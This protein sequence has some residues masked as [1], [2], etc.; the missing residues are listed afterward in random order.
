MGRFSNARQ[1]EGME[2]RFLSVFAPIESAKRIQIIDMLR[3]VALLGILL[4]NVGRLW[5]SLTYLK[6]QA[7]A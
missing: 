1:E 5:R 7:H 2:S 3:G 6:W 4:V